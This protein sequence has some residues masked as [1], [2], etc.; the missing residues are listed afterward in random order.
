VLNAGTPTSPN[1]AL[2][3]V[4]QRSIQIAQE[5]L[6][7][8]NLPPLSLDD[9]KSQTANNVINPTIGDLQNT[10]KTDSERGAGVERLGKILRIVEKYAKIVGTAIQHN[11]QFSSLV[12]EE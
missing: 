12:W 5:K 4:W 7:E 11:P 8:K 10:T 6:S 3:V 2:A 1:Q 9:Q